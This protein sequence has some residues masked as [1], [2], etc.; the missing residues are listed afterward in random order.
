MDYSIFVE[1]QKQY[2]KDKEEKLK[3]KEFEKKNKV[4]TKPK[5][6]QVHLV[7]KFNDGNKHFYET[8]FIMVENDIEKAKEEDK[9]ISIVHNNID[10][11]NSNIYN[12]KYLQYISC[13]NKII[14]KHYNY[15][16]IL[17]WYYGNNIMILYIMYIL[18]NR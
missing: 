11:N 2:E 9:F 18:Y 8:K 12:D 15:N 16:N 4:K 5:M 1:R 10:N 14:S 7:A 3:Q 13:N 6:L 17:L